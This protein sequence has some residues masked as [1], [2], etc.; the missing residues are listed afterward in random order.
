MLHFIGCVATFHTWV[1]NTFAVEFHRTTLGYLFRTGFLG[2]M[3]APFTLSFV[4]MT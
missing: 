3:K 4:V 2:N 1:V